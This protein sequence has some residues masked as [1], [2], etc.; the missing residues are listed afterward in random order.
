MKLH[1]IKAQSR[2][3][4]AVLHFIYRKDLS[5]NDRYSETVIQ[6]LLALELIKQYK[7]H[8]FKTEKSKNFKA[9]DFAKEFLWTFHNTEYRHL[10]NNRRFIL[11]FD[12]SFENGQKLV[13]IEEAIKKCYV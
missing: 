1:Q 5:I 9:I 2:T 8:Y 12:T 11:C 7:S 6:G 4:S 10:Q 13:E 3:L